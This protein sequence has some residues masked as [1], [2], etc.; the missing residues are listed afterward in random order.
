MTKQT[1]GNKNPYF[2]AAKSIRI[3]SLDQLQK[4]FFSTQKNEGVYYDKRIYIDESGVEY[5]PYM[6]SKT[7]DHDINS[8]FPRKE[9]VN[10]ILEALKNG[11]IESL[12]NIPKN[13]NAI[14]KLEG[15]LGS[16]SYNL[17]GKD[18]SIIFPGEYYHVDSN[19]GVFEMA[20][21]Y[22]KALARD[23][24]FEEY[25]SNSI[26][27]QIVQELNSYPV[28]TSPVDPNTH[29]ITPETLFR[30]SFPGELNGPY[31]SQFLLQNFDYGN[32][33]IEQKYKNEVDNIDSLQKNIWLDI[34]NGVISGDKNLNE[35]FFHV[36]NGRVL[37]AKVHNDPLFQFYYNSTLLAFQ[38][39]IKPTAFTHENTTSWTSG[40]GP[41]VLS[42]V[43][44]VCLGALRCSWY[45]KYNLSMKIRPEVYAQR[46][47]LVHNANIDASFGN[48]KVDKVP[49]LRDIYN[50]INVS[51]IL[52]MIQNYNTQKLGISSET[53]NVYLPLQFKEGSP[54]HPSWTAGHAAVAGAAVT[55]MKAMLECHE[56]QENT[57]VSK[58]WPGDIFVPEISDGNSTLVQKTS[59]SNITIVGELNKLASN[60]SLGRDF[61]GVHYR[62]DGTCGLFIG[63]EYAI[64][65]LI[66]LAKEF[67]ESQINLFDGWILEKFDGTLIKIT[68]KGA[69]N[70]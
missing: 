65:Y 69:K 23:I 38:N 43:S 62:C 56:K 17:I 47:Q 31:I 55:V 68:A 51:N 37:G 2:L 59:E 1:E 8:G 27:S 28:K 45:S 30:G 33:F 22:A 24:P 29:Q 70:L 35:D 50:K 15:V 19:E 57:Y 42:A 36:Y 14:L 9:D 49:G 7:L 6:F 39:G 34:Q 21:V 11:T 3:N 12:D 63:E 44:N 20:E 52:E 67:H 60:V 61:A 58:N 48:D 41:S 4:D 32:L 66:D 13:S 53:K 5:Y 16:S 64:S 46:L 18:P 10:K 25:S 54:T 26:I 40:G